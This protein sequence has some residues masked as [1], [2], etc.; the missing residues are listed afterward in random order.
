MLF[1][2]WWYTYTHRKRLETRRVASE[3][4]LGQLPYFTIEDGAVDDFVGAELQLV[5]HHAQI[6]IV[7]VRE[8][9]SNTVLVPHVP[10]VEQQ[11]ARLSCGDVRTHGILVESVDNLRSQRSVS[12][13]PAPV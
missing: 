1:R 10:V 11:Q 3:V 8:E 2:Y 13:A 12:P 5:E 7:D 6:Q 9:H 4:L